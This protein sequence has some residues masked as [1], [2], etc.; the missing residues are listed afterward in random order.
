MAIP[1]IN[2]MSTAVILNDNY[3]NLKTTAKHSMAQK[4]KIQTIFN[5]L[6]INQLYQSVSGSYFTFCKHV[7]AKRRQHKRL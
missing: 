5:H 4:G 7:Q 3:C 1:A 2:T 6:I